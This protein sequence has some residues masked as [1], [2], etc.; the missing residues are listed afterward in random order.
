MPPQPLSRVRPDAKNISGE[1]AFKMRPKIALAVA[2]CLDAWSWVET[3]TAMLY[4]AL[5]RTN[6]EQAV[7]YFCSLESAKAK[8]DA[9][10]VAAMNLL[11]E[12]EV[13]IINALL[14]YIKSQQSTRDRMAHWLWATSGDLLD[15][16]LIYDPKVLMKSKAEFFAALYGGMSYEEAR[17]AAPPSKVPKGDLYIYTEEALEKDRINFNNLLELITSA[18]VL[19]GTSLT[20][21][22]RAQIRDEIAKDARLAEYL[23]PSPSADR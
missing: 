12:T 17:K 10:R 23:S 9:I 18:A 4:V 7:D 14:R 19:C 8:T 20:D 22:T 2:R 21:P 3:Q 1:D 16:I 6:H 15:D 11:P 5:C 13:R